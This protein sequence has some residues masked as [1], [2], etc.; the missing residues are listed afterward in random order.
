VPTLKNI[1]LVDGTTN[2]DGRITTYANLLASG[3]KSDAIKPAPEDTAGLIYTS[4]TTG[5][6]K[7]VILTHL[8]LAANVSAIHEIVP[9]EKGDRSLSFL[10]WAHSFGQTGELHMLLSMGASMAIC[11][12]VDKLL[13]DLAEVKPT[14]LMSVPRIFNKSYTAVQQQLA[15]K[16]KPVQELVKIALKITAKER[17]GARLR[18]RELAL[19]EG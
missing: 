16:P 11:E 2:G 15:S 12:N 18:G 1:V 10:P 17:R 19:L 8:N 5:N 14:V 9:I 3:H 7:G 6:P 13:E 4:G